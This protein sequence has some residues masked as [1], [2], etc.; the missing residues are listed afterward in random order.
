MVGIGLG[1]GSYTASIAIPNTIQGNPIMQGFNPWDCVTWG[2]L[3]GISGGVLSWAGTGVALG[4]TLGES[5]IGYGITAGRRGEWNVEGA[6]ETG[7]FSAV[8]FGAG[9]ASNR[10]IKN[11]L[12]KSGVY[13]LSTTGGYYIGQTQNFPQRMLQHNSAGGILNRNSLLAKTYY[14]MPGS[15]KLEREVYEQFRIENYL[16]KGY[17]LLNLRLPMGGRMDLY[18][19][20]IDEVINKYRLT[21]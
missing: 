4:V 1:A 10:L 2:M 18:N 19:D 12:T 21:R 3:G 16:R 7:A 11:A 8:L 5:Q 14:K 20:M 6:L 13:E 9:S 17:S 15:S